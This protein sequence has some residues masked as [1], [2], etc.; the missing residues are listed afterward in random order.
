MLAKKDFLHFV[1]LLIKQASLFSLYI[2]LTSPS[3]FLN[4]RDTV[5]VSVYLILLIKQTG[6]SYFES[7][8]SDNTLKIPEILLKVKNVL[9][10][11]QTKLSVWLQI[12]AP[13][14][15]FT[16]NNAVKVQNLNSFLKFI[17][18]FFTLIKHFNGPLIKS[19]SKTQIYVIMESQVDIIYC[20]N[21]SHDVRDGCTQDAIRVFRC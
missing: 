19:F 16:A 13:V 12:S 6:L 7:I 20:T 10:L 17:Y 14:M 4:Q 11:Q 3:A 5:H 18:H 2:C 1:C 9:T 15:T 8:G 21:P